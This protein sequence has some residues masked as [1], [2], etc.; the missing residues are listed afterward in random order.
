MIEEIE[1]GIKNAVE[2]GSSLEDA[3]KTFVSAGYN[4]VEVKEAAKNISQGVTNIVNPPNKNDKSEPKPT[5]ESLEQYQTPQQEN[6]NAP[7]TLSQQTT[8]SQPQSQ[9]LSQAIRQGEPLLLKPQG[10]SRKRKILIILLI[11]LLLVVGALIFVT[12]FSKE[13]LQLISKS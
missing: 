7:Q 4:P 8:P 5:Q 6:Q 9:P 2:R 10:S 3:V 11:I 1:A 12:Y 13:L